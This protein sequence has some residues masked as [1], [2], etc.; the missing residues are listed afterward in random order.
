MDPT[1]GEED[2]IQIVLDNYNHYLNTLILE[3]VS[4][5]MADRCLRYNKHQSKKSII[6]KL[7]CFIIP[8]DPSR[9]LCGRDAQYFF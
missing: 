9:V 7:F 4:E 8:Q 3:H 2:S 5:I 6:N 1:T